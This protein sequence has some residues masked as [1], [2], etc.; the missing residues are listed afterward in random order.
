MKD[1]SGI[2]LYLFCLIKVYK[3]ADLFSLYL[4]GVLTIIFFICYSSAKRENIGY[5]IQ[6]KNI[7]LKQ[8]K[9]FIDILNHDIK[10]PI[11][12][13]LMALGV[14]NNGI[15]GRVNAE[16]K[17]L[18]EQIEHS[19]RYTLDMISMVNNAHELDT[20]SE[21]LNYEKFNMTDLLF[22]CLNELSCSV[23][24]K[25]LTFSYYSK[26]NENYVEADL[27]EIKKVVISLLI[28]AINYSNYGGEIAVNINRTGSR[29]T[30]SISGMELL[31][32]NFENKSKYATIGHNIGMY[33]CKKI[34][35]FHKGKFYFLNRA[36]NTLAFVIPTKINSF[37]LS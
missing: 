15:M 13:Q 10:V 27:P 11:L 8:K 24:E 25:N 20:N 29:L 16:Q 23:K 2:L 22:S 4:L 31:G 37:C 5:K 28:N 34:I 33:L 19:C 26:T 9:E 3:T 17:E 30:F 1:L 21:K 35:E 14:L 32:D 12:A 7:S 6:F 18:I 36:K